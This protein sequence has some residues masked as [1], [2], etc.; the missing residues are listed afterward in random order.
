MVFSYQPQNHTR[1]TSHRVHAGILLLALLTLYFTQSI[2]VV[3]QPTTIIVSTTADTGPG[4]LRDALLRVQTGGV[5][6]FSPSVFPPDRPTVIFVKTSLPMLTAANVTLDGSKNDVILDGF[7]VPQVAAGLSIDAAACKIYGVTIRNFRGDGVFMTT[8]ATDC[9]IGGQR[10]VGG[11]PLGRGNQIVS[12]Q[13][14]GISIRGSR[15]FIWGNFIGIDRQG[16]NAAGNG[17]NGIAILEGATNNIVGDVSDTKRNLI[18]GNGENGLLIKGAG[19]NANQVIGNYIGVDHKG[20]T[21][22]SNAKSGVAIHDGAQGNI[23]GGLVPEAGNLISGNGDYGVYMTDVNTNNNQLLGNIIGADAT[24]TNRLGQGTDGVNIANGASA[25]HIGNGTTAGRNLISSNDRDGVRIEGSTSAGNQVQGNFIGT[26]ATGLLALPNGLHGVELTLETHHNRIGGSRNIG[27]APIGEGNLLSGNLNHGVVVT[28]GAYQNEVLGN[29]I[30]PNLVGNRTLDNHPFGGIDIAD[31]AHDNTIGEAAP[32]EGNIIS[33]NRTDGIALFHTIEG[34]IT[35]NNRVIGNLIG[36]TLSGDQPLPNIGPGIMNGIGAEGTYIAQNKI[37]YNQGA[38]VFLAGCNDFTITKN[39]IFSN[40]L[41]AIDYDKSAGNL[42]CISPPVITSIAL[43][44]NETI[45]GT[46]QANSQIE[47]YADDDNEGRIYEG[48]R[49]T[50]AQGNF[51]F[52][53]VGKFSGTNITVVG[54]DPSG[55]TS[56]F[57]SPVHLQWTLL[58]LMNGDNDLGEFIFDTVDQIKG[59]GGSP[60]ANV[61]A[62]VDGY[63]DSGPRAGTV[64]YDLTTSPST[65]I[66]T[67]TTERNMGDGQTLIDFVTL[68]RRLHPARHLLLAIIDHGGGWAPGGDNS[69]VGALPHKRNWSAGTSGLSWDF[70][71]DHDYLNNQE[72]RQTM[73]TITSNGAQPIDVLFYDVCLMGLLE[74]AYELQGYA[75]Y[76]VSSQNI[77]WAPAGPQNRYNQLINNLMPD[78][79]PQDL[80]RLLVDSYAKDLPD[81]GHPYTISA[82]DLSQLANLL[83]KVNS[84]ANALSPTLTD[85]KGTDDLLSAYLLTQK[86][87]YDSDLLLEPTTDG[88]IDLQDFALKISDTYKD[89]A[90]VTAAQDVIAAVNNIVIAERHRSGSPWKYKE[91]TWNLDNVHG[92]SIF[93]PLGED[94]QLPLPISSTLPID[95]TGTRNIRLRDTYTTRELRFVADSTWGTM[96]ERYYQLKDGTIPTETTTGPVAGLQEPDIVPP[97][98]TLTFVGN[99]QV[100]AD[101]TLSWN[102]ND[103]KSGVRGVTIW[104]KQ[105]ENDWLQ[106]GAST[107]PSGTQSVHLAT[108]C[109]NSFAVNGTDQAGNIEP[110]VPGANMLVVD[111]EPCYRSYLPAIA[112]NATRQY[113]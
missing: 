85:T 108:N 50:D 104:Q 9:E 26:T 92:L 24:G 1:F 67:D 69:I 66:D 7:L 51:V 64:L 29:I 68:G 47:V 71:N 58:L 55:N 52:T 90:V 103:A 16:I 88:F 36:L 110:I 34:R 53:K 48:S 3:A 31:G 112:N 63:T 43:G 70:T 49:T 59:L 35:P 87:D 12:N 77:G 28:S 76:F 37:A 33:G 82:L 102:S 54:I 32:G 94:L 60:R 113:R 19:A 106:I 95:E 4:S 18:S 83:S 79:T 10:T 74:V 98:S 81:Q 23:I 100:G 72:I 13:G 44:V 97:Q 40:T 5:I 25:N 38:G 6:T 11:G 109:R 107:A 89:T 14:D 27:D 62:L 2:V 21:K 30:G 22:V 45:T 15:N 78:A 96:I 80:A 86:L 46:Y 8:N 39:S 75:S 93:L 91:R 105:A 65:I 57:S 73:A 17:K 84:L 20:K 56:L 41:T 61:L 42:T 101:I 111:V 99:Q